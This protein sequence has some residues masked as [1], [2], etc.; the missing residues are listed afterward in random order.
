MRTLVISEDRPIHAGK[1]LSKKRCRKPDDAVIRLEPSHK[2][3]T[4]CVS[5]YSNQTEAHKSMHLVDVTPHGLTPI[6]NLTHI[7]VRCH[8][9]QVPL[10][11]EREP[12]KYAIKHPP[13]PGVG[14]RRCAPRHVQKSGRHLNWISSHRLYV[15]ILAGKKRSLLRVLAPQ[16]F[17][18]RHALRKQPARRVPPRFVLRLDDDRAHAY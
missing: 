10:T 18:R 17:I 8:R 4:A 5:V 11:A 2:L 13:T 3:L 12:P 6:L 14:M 16:H 7:T 1:S 15:R 9:E